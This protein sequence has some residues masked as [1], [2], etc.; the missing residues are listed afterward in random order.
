VRVHVAQSDPPTPRSHAAG[1][2]AQQRERERAAL[3]KE[4]RIRWRERL[5]QYN[6]EYR[7]REQ[8][9]LS[10]PLDLVNSSSGKEEES[11]WERT[12]SN[13]W[14]PAPPSSRAEGAAVELIPEVGAEPPSTG[15]SVEVPA[16]T[17][18]APADAVEVPPALKEEEAGLLQFGIGVAFL[19]ARP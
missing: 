4:R 3:A 9:G 1:R 16:G 19:H 17:T 15:L 12:D 8:Q 10:P 2:T 14:E 7:L 18:E 5:E 11:D 6:E 13:R